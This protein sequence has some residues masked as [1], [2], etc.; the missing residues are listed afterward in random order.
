VPGAMAALVLNK[1]RVEHEL[2]EHF[3]AIAAEILR[4]KEAIPTATR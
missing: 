1:W 3:D 4:R 2:R